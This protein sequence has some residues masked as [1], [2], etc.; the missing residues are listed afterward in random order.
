MLLDLCRASISATRAFTHCLALTSDDRDW[1]LPTGQVILSCLLLDLVINGFYFVLFCF[2]IM[3]ALRW[4]L[5]WNTKIFVL[6]SHSHKFIHSSLIQTLLILIF[7]LVLTHWQSHLLVHESAYVLIQ[8]RKRIKE[9]KGGKKEKE[10][11]K[12]WL[13]ISS[14]R[15]G[16][17]RIF[18]HSLS[19]WRL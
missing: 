13:L 6:P 3:D 8:R 2:Y 1:L 10:P 14:Q 5:S 16:R 4:S 18:P 17:Y 19:I 15:Y 12:Y 11:L 7:P 9:K